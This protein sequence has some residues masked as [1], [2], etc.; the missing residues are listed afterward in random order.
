MR[1]LATTSGALSA[2]TSVA[3]PGIHCRN[4]LIQL[5]N[6][7]ST[8][9]NRTVHESQP[10]VKNVKCGAQAIIAI[11][12][13]DAMNFAVPVDMANP[14]QAFTDDRF[15]VVDLFVVA[16]VLPMATPFGFV[17]RAVGILAIGR[18]LEQPGDARRRVIRLTLNNL[19]FNRIAGGCAR[20]KDN[21]LIR[22][23]QP[24]AAVN[25]FFDL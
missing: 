11:G 14:F 25:E 23:R 20:N 3:V 9:P 1:K 6:E 17:V 24:I 21:A 18:R 15:L 4:E 13:G 16:D 19:C 7:R 2:F 22:A 10:A 5:G 12:A 8:I